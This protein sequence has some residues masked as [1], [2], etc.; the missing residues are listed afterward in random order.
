MAESA[1]F[2]RLDVGKGLIDV[3]QGAPPSA[4]APLFYILFV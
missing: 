1:Q 3:R 4:G 2:A